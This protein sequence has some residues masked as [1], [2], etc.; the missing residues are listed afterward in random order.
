ML[1]GICCLLSLTQE[2]GAPVFRYTKANDNNRT[3]YTCHFTFKDSN[4]DVKDPL[5]FLGCNLHHLLLLFWSIFMR[6]NE[7]TRYNF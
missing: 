4:L 3:W 2:H 1:S 5:P 7:W 6:R